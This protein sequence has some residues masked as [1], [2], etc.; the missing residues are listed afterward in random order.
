[1]NTNTT[2]RYMY[3]LTVADE[4]V[5]KATAT[6][7]V[8]AGPGASRA[9]IFTHLINNS[10]KGELCYTNFAVLYFSLERDAL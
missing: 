5:G 6:G 10:I 4:C 7:T 2:T 3:I 8:D 1:M 9:D